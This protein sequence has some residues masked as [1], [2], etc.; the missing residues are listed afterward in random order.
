MSMTDSIADMLTRVRNANQALHDKVDIP[1]SK[2]KLEIAKIM[3]EE[4]LVK[5]YKMIE[6]KKQGILR[7]YLKYGPGNQRILTRLER[8]SRPGLRVYVKKREMAKAK[9]GLGVAVVSTSKGVMTDKRAQEM[10][11]GGELICYME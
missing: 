4:G 7:I 11:L 9:K 6:D 10:G 3:K 5:N 1:S 2:L 8:I